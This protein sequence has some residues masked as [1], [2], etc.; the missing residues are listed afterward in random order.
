[1]L[2]KVFY[3]HKCIADRFGAQTYGPLI[4][5]RP[6]HSLDKGLLEHEKIHVKQFWKN[7][8]FGLWYLFSKKSRFAYEVEAFKEQLKYNPEH[9]DLYASFLSTKYTLGITKEQALSALKS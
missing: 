4:F 7:P 6:Q 1:M 9:L 8:L 3:T 5:I 2:F